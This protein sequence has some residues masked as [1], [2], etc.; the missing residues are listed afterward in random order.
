MRS[1]SRFAKSHPVQARIIII[2]SHILLV[3]IA[4]YLSA[5]LTHW[6]I[7]FSTLW[8]CFSL[9]GFF[10]V[11][12]FY[13]RRQGGVIISYAK[14]KGF[15]F[16]V[17]LSGFAVFFSTANFLNQPKESLTPVMATHIPNPLYK[18]PQAEKLLNAFASGEKNS[19]TKKE[20]RIIRQ[21]FNHQVKQWVKAKISGDRSK[22]AQIALIILSIIAAL[23]LLYLV[24]ALACSLSCNGSDVAAIIVGVVG[25]AAVIWLLIK[26]IKAINRKKR[27]PTPDNSN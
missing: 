6:G 10:V 11:G 3:L 18:N 23:G 22:G 8:L 13:P 27:E 15:D 1:L 24:A 16:L 12:M 25:A 7:R 19:F 17:A 4:F 2:V 20:K 14:R 9:L 5:T 21:E 26:V